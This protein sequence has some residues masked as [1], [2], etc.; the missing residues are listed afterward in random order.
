MGGGSEAELHPQSFPKIASKG[1]FLSF[2]LN[3]SFFSEKNLTLM[4]GKASARR[5]WF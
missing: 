5:S 2:R 3:F 1:W 4:K